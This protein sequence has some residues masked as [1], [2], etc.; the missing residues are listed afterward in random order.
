MSKILLL[1]SNSL[2]YRAYYALPYM[3]NA[4]GQPT[5]AVYGFISMLARLIKEEKPTHIAAVFDHKGK[6][7]RQMEYP[8]YK[9]TRKPMPEEL[10]AQ[11]PLI[12]R[13]LQDMGI[14]ILSKEGYEADDIIGTIAKRFAVPTIILTGDRDCLQLVDYTTAVYYTLRGVTNVKKYDLQAMAEEGLTPAQ[15]IEYKAIAGDKSDNIPGAQGIG[16]VSARKLLAD[17]KDIETIYRNIEQVK[18]SLQQKL[19]ASKDLVLLSKRLATIDTSVPLE[20][21]MVDLSFYPVLNEKAL[22]N[23]QALGTQKP[24]RAV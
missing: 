22:E 7:K 18:G 14:K 11:L 8:E 24:Y 20:C 2:L 12:S 13:L 10:V 6:I 23:M 21:S 9:A 3:E 16:D 4:Q 19:L 17:Y 1:D 15:I 5:A